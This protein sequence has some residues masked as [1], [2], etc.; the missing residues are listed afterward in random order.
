MLREENKLL[1]DE[2]KVVLS[3]AVRNGSDGNLIIV[4]FTT[5]YPL[6][7]S[8]KYTQRAEE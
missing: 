5:C 3:K 4:S 1:Q 8:W 6:T 2:V 7:D